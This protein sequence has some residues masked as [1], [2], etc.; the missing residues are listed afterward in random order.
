MQSKSNVNQNMYN[1]S[2]FMIMVKKVL[3]VTAVAALFAVA[4]YAQNP[5]E[6]RRSECRNDDKECIYMHGAFEGLDLSDKQIAKLDKIYQDRENPK[7]MKKA[8]MRQHRFDA[9]KDALKK[10]KDILTPDQYVRYL[11]NVVLMQTCKPRP[12]PD[13][14]HHRPAGHHS[15]PPLPRPMG[16]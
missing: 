12:R 6:Y 14:H 2:D 11:E 10:I 13:A 3:M 15:N 8:E 4:S 5:R 9:H 16:K 7:K 1:K